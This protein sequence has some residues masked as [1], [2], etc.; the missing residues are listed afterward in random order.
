MSMG[1]SI[2]Q[3]VAGAISTV[4]TAAMAAVASVKAAA[5]AAICL[6]V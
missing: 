3:A 5:R 2:Q 4:G 1:K 6:F